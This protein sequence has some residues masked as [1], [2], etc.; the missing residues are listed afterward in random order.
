MHSHFYL[1]TVCFLVLPRMCETTKIHFEYVGLL[2]WKWQDLPFLAV[3]LPVTPGADL[4]VLGLVKTHKDEDAVRRLKVRFQRSHFALV[5][6]T[7]ELQPP[8]SDSG[9]RLRNEPSLGRAA[10]SAL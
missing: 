8:V 9:Y 6:F 1:I 7:H 5:I 2:D 10:G 4:P 3:D